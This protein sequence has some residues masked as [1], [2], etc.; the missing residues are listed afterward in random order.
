MRG[1]YSAKNEEDGYETGVIKSFYF[2]PKEKKYQ[3]RKYRPV[4]LPIYMR[5][6]PVSWRDIDKG[7]GELA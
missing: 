5:E 2:V 3:M 1:Y 7:I 6:F 4:K